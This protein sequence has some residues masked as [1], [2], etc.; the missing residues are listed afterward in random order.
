M[1]KLEELKQAIK[2]TPPERLARV[3]YR[4]HFM[5]MFGVLIVCSIL[6][7]RGYWWIIFA[8]IFSL[9]VSYSQGVSS[10]QKYN[11]IMEIIG[12][13]EY[14][15]IKD[16]SPTRKR[17][18]IIKQVFPKWIWIVAAAKAGLIVYMWIPTNAWYM[19]ISRAMIFILLYIT[20]YFFL[21][22]WVAKFIYDR[23]KNEN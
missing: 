15:P 4:S 7:Y 19:W 9:G 14:D 22:Y 1:N 21:Y 3:E 5:Q 10:Y 16:K 18:Y 11:A 12:K 8:F 13:K 2:N 23:R 17:D 6:I 20:I